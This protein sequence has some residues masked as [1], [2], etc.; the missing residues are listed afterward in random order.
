[1]GGSVVDSSSADASSRSVLRMLEWMQ[2]RGPDGTGTFKKD[3][4]ALGSC[5]LAIT[6][7]ELIP[8]PM[9]S[10]GCPWL[11]AFNGELYGLPIPPGRSDTAWLR[12]RVC[13]RGNDGLDALDGMYALALANPEAEEVWLARDPFG[14]KPLFIQEDGDTFRFASELQPLWSERA[15]PAVIDPQA[16]VEYVS[17]SRRLGEESPF[18]EI[19][20]FAPG[21]CL[22]V[23]RTGAGLMCQ[24]RRLA[25]P[26]AEGLP[27][28][29]SVAEAAESVGT[30][31]ERSVLNCARTSRRLGLFISGGL[32]STIVAAILAKHGVEDVDTFSL[33][34]ERNGPEGDGVPDLATLHL[35]GSS[36]RSWQH[37]ASH[38]TAGEVNQAFEE[39]LAL[40]SE[41]CFPM[42]A[43][44]TLLLS[45]MAAEAGVKVVLTG[46]GADELFAG[47]ESYR[48][49]LLS[50]Q[51]AGPEDF[52]LKDPVFQW[53]LRVLDGTV[54]E[55]V[56][57]IRDQ[58]RED[59]G[60]ESP[61]AQLLRHERRMSLRPLLDRL[62]LTSM[63]RSIEVRVPFLHGGVGALSEKAVTDWRGLRTTKPLLR[64]AFAPLLGP[65]AWEIAKRPLRIAPER[66]LARGNLQRVRETLLSPTTREVLPLKLEKVEELLA[67]LNGEFSGPAALVAVRVYQLTR[68]CARFAD[69][70][71]APRPTQASAMGG[72]PGRAVTGIGSRN[73]RQEKDDLDAPTCR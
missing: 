10:E 72:E 19:S 54:D 22:L 27:E 7:P 6:G 42:S 50:E 39:V 26:Q 8:T 3:G 71:P 45:D 20:S 17:L 24:T 57:S 43:A 35:P 31:L 47:Y 62:D 67:E 60:R 49:F 11:L 55:V 14:I 58:L 46:E 63:R 52:Y 44:Y 34:L 4:I 36:W 61:L 56:A 30:A 21:T 1:M 16:F 51:A 9:L 65:R 23:R 59:T 70:T 68:F 5:R 69:G 2:H 64:R 13:S 25:L 40:T 48:A 73:R 28:E 15:S 38:P 33:L 18:R 41:P 53:T 32:D 66:W 29:L 37:H 12:E